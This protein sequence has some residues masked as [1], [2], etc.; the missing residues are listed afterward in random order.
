[1]RGHRCKY[2]FYSIHFTP[3]RI[4]ERNPEIFLSFYI[5][6]VAS[7]K[8]KYIDRNLSN[9]LIFQ[10]QCLLSFPQDDKE[11]VYKGLVLK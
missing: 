3:D 5:S 7:T 6:F 8:D 10:L 9:D 1:M 4:S 2:S 11:I